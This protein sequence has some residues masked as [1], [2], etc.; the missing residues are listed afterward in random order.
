MEAE[1][2]EEIYIDDSS[3]V[4]NER[5]SLIRERL[6]AFT[7]ESV[8][9][10]LREFFVTAGKAVLK[11]SG[12]EKPDDISVPEN[13]SV[14]S[15]FA[16]ELSLKS[17]EYKK[18]ICTAGETFLQL[19]F[20]YEESEEPDIKEV[21]DVVYSYLYDYAAEFIGGS[22]GE[23]FLTE[24]LFTERDDRFIDTGISLF[25]GDRMKARILEVLKASGKK[26]TVRK[27][28]PLSGLAEHKKNTVSELFK[29]ASLLM[30]VLILAVS[31]TA[32][33]GRKEKEKTEETET[34]EQ[35]EIYPETVSYVSE[36]EETT[37]Y[38]GV[39]HATVL[40]VQDGEKDG[41]YVYTL[42]DESDPENAWA[43][44][45]QD[46]GEIFAGMEK[47]K[48]VSVLFSGDMIED[49]D[50]VEF[51]AILED[52]KYKIRSVEGVTAANMMSSFS[53]K[54][55]DG[56]EYTFLKDNCHV[57]RDAL[58]TEGKSKVIVYYADCGAA[59]LYPVR[60][61]KVK[62]EKKDR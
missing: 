34:E 25:V 16:D 35:K 46:I 30:T 10:D 42:R 37:D 41:L 12:G 49:T 62:D 36:D 17:P 5:L 22:Q 57:D 50:N 14:L 40:N 38:F 9:E 60:V 8:R 53:V 48:K 52:E 28:I 13:E 54:A 43:L 2:K 45:S 6:S 26:C 11:L 39:M 32:C 59:E 47:G 15:F 24:F 4:I 20:L 61:Y 58:S 1:Y 55:K 44:N 3:E 33:G 23:N 19:L 56:K 27:S 29:K 21:K 18:G 7:G 31:L 51:I